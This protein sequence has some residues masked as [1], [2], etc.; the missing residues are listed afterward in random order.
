MF[1]IIQKK[2]TEHDEQVSFVRWFRL[3]FPGVLIFAI[4]NGGHRHPAVAAKLKAEGATPGVPDLFIPQ[5]RAW[6]EMKR[7]DGGRASKEQ[8][9]MKEYLESCGY[10]VKICHGAENAMEVIKEIANA[11][12]H[13]HGQVQ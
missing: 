6:V 12:N 9:A 8:K 10:L 4:P 3:Q 5:W 11:N 13:K 7:S 2:A 1:D